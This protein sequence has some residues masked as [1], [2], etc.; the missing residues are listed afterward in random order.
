VYALAC[1]VFAVLL[2][3][4]VP[5]EVPEDFGNEEDAE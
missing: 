4:L 1:V 2:V 3:P 5:R